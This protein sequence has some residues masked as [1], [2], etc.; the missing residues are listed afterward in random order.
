MSQPTPY[1]QTTDFSQQEANNASGRSTVNTAA[2]DAEFANIETTLDQ[3]LD[4]LQKIQ[5]DD[6]KLKDLAV[7]VN[8]LSPEILNL[9]GGFRIVGDGVWAASTAYQVKDLASDENS[10]YVCIQAHTSGATFDP[11]YWSRFGFTIGSDVSDAAANA[12]ASAAA[13]LSSANAAASSASAAATSATNS[14]TSATASAS[15]ASAAIASKNLTLQYA[16]QVEN[17]LA[18]LAVEATQAEMEAGTETD[19]RA[20][21][22]LRVKQAIEALTPDH[23][24][25]SQGE[26]VGSIASQ[27]E[28]GNSSIPETATEIEILCV[29]VT[30]SSSGRIVVQVGSASYITTGYSGYCLE[31]PSGDSSLTTGFPVTFA[32]SSVGYTGSITLSKIGTT[33]K[34]IMKSTGV[35][36]TLM[37]VGVGSVDVSS[38]LSRVRVSLAGGGSFSAGTV[39]IKWK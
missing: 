31:R 24:W 22:P 10:N 16:T 19:N 9:M 20:M 15:S 26:S 14:A 7:G 17:S 21:S 4:N 5:R 3:T 35:S 27:T 25:Y 36:N 38:I 2:L 37:Q 28:F 8:A 32:A 6:G 39:S 13:A 33:N 12:A 11:Q 34:W 18:Y 30:P 1:T 23:I 29:S